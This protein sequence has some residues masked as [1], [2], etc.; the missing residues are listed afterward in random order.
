MSRMVT[1]GRWSRSYVQDRRLI[2]GR[3]Q[4][5]ALLLL[6]GVLLAWPSF[7]VGTWLR[8]GTVTMITLIAVV[9][10]QLLVGLTD[11]VSVG[12]SAFMGIGGFTAGVLSAQLGWGIGL[13]LI[14]GAVS[15]AVIGVVFGLPT[16]R[17]RGFYLAL[18]TLAVQYVF[19]FTIPRLPEDLFGGDRGL[20]LPS[21]TLFG[22]PINGREDLYYV[23]L[24][25]AAMAVVLAL[26]IQE[27]SLGRAFVAIRDN[28]IAAELTGVPVRR[29]KLLAFAIA[30]SFAGAAGVLLAYE[31]SYVGVTQ[32]TLFLSVWF[33]G[34]LI[35][36]GLGSVLGAVLGVISL[37][38]I[39]EFTELY[40]GEFFTS[41]GIDVAGRTGSLVNVIVGAAICIMLIVEPRGLANLY[42]HLERSVRLWPLGYSRS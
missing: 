4:V 39:Q 31:S 13:T 27:S 8:F 7:M 6:V 38:L 41:I 33:L 42:R 12:Q 34:M 40:G 9:G 25:I 26:A 24:A 10:L 32:F 2:R 19:V 29:L 23:A 28:E 22:R 16:L 18:T 30:S 1:T 5:V 15:A 3:Y 35:I 17:I 37:S 11:Q 21:L 36:G 20:F 14:A